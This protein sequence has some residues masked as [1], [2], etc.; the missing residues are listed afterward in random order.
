MMHTINID[1]NRM[2]RKSSSHR[3]FCIIILLQRIEPLHV[4]YLSNLETCVLMYNTSRQHIS[5]WDLVRDYVISEMSKSDLEIKNRRTTRNI[6]EF[7]WI[8]ANLLWSPTSNATHYFNHYLHHIWS[9]KFM[10]V[11]SSIYNI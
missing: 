2:P 11:L 5:C 1:H 3:I 9:W 8:L 4:L 7:F 10:F 6:D